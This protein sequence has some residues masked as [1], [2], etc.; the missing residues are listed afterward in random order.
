MAVTAQDIAIALRIVTSSTDDLDDAISEQLTRLASVA[1]ALVS[2]Y[3]PNAPDEIKDEAAIRIASYLFD[4]SP[5]AVNAPQNAFVH[6]GAQSLLSFWRE[7][8]ATPIG[9]PTESA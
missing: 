5:G 3:A 1:S 8:R 2:A 4:V 7:Q 6:S 9:K